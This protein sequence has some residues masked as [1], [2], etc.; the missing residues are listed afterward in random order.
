MKERQA[1]LDKLL[2]K[3][4]WPIKKI[5]GH[6]SM[7]IKIRPYFIFALSALVIL[8]SCATQKSKVTADAQTKLKY[9]AAE[10]A[11]YF[12]GLSDPTL[13]GFSYLV[14]KEGK[15]IL[16]GGIGLAHVENKKLNSTDTIFRVGSITKQFTAVSILQL[17]EQG[18]L[19]LSD[20]LSKYFPELPN[21]EKITLRN[22]LNHTSGM[23]EQG[24]HL[25]S[26]CKKIS[27]THWE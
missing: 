25:P 2:R 27:L 4:L 19:S 9:H 7:I 8:T 3:M 12:E 14:S 23:W 5:E 22:L 26:I 10:L 20:N 16:K 15:I 6:I 13:P 17:S 18:K 11:E 1:Y 21:S 24:F